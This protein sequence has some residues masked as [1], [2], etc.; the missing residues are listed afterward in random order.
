MAT[1]GSYFPSMATATVRI[2]PHPDRGWVWDV[3]VAGR[4]VGAGDS[5][6]FRRAK[7]H[8]VEA[9]AQALAGQGEIE[10]VKRTYLRRPRVVARLEAGSVSR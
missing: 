2:D 9:A 5:M 1:T 4:L 7:R 3:D 10:V 8:A 6:F